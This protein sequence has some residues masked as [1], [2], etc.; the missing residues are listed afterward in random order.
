MHSVDVKSFSKHFCLQVE[1][2]KVFKILKIQISYSTT[3]TETNY[4]NHHAVTHKSMKLI[5]RTGFH[6]RYV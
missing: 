2:L 1:F 4:L 5:Q 3:E 6:L